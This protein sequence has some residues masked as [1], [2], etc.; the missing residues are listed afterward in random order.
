M[1]FWSSLSVIGWSGLLRS[2]RV[3][4]REAL[5]QLAGDADDDLGRPEAGHLLGLLERDRAVV[6]DRRDV[7]D[8]ARLHVRQA[9]A[10]AAD[11]PDGAVAVS[12]ISKTSALANSVPTSSAVQ[13][14]S[15]RPGRRAARSGARRPSRPP[16]LPTRAA[17]HRGRRAAGEPVA[18]RAPALGH[19][20]AAA[21]LGRRSRASR[22]GRGRRPR[23]RARRGRRVDRHEE[24]RLVGV[25][26]ERDRRPTRAPPRTSLAHALER[27]DRLE[28]RRRAPRAGRRARAPRAAA[29][30]SPGFGEPG[31]RRPPCSRCFVSRSSSWSA[32][33][34]S[35]HRVDGLGADGLGRPLER[36]EPR[37]ARARR[38]R[39]RSRASIRRMP[40]P[41]LRSP[42]MTKL[43]IWPVARQCVPP[44]SS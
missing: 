3:R 20:G 44:H 33:I 9:L 35:G 37:R 24:L 36:V 41:M 15:A 31:R 38:R 5:D 25:E 42:V 26:A 27:V 29:T 8:R 12:S 34:R 13:A 40:E 21:A 32:A 14:A 23:C 16:R 11:A 22:P 19:L 17:R 4:R 28:R 43:P 30:S 6:D 10:L 2:W 1:S 39:R 7:G 18:P